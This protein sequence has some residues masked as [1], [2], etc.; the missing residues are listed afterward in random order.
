[1]VSKKLSVKQY[2]KKSF[3]S[4]LLTKK[5]CASGNGDDTKEYYISM[6]IYVIKAQAT[7]KEK[8]GGCNSYLDVFLGSV[9]EMGVH[10]AISG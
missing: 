8:E 7:R 5:S 2:L 1:M 3:S 9:G 6:F 4:A 10:C